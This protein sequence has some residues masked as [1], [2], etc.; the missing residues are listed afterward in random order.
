MFMLNLT[1]ISDSFCVNLMP[2]HL[3]E[4]AK[5]LMSGAAFGPKESRGHNQDQNIAR[6]NDS[7]MQD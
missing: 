5:M 3:I 2:K 1:Y 4:S 6:V 7:V